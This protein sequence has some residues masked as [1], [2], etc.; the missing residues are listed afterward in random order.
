MIRSSLFLVLVI[1]GASRAT[2]ANSIMDMI[3]EEKVEKLLAERKENASL[4]IEE[5]RQLMA[6]NSVDS[7]DYFSNRD[8][9]YEVIN[10][11]FD[12][13]N[14]F[15]FVFKLRFAFCWSNQNEILKLPTISEKFNAETLF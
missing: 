3:N 7:E 12:K 15:F 14:F 8:D 4:E 13:F 1:F 5:R 6:K 2:P 11:L 10:N 9:D